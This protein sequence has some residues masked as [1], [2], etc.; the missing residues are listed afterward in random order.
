M[1]DISINE[2]QVRLLSKNN[3]ALFCKYYRE[4]SFTIYSL[5]YGVLVFT[6]WG[7]LAWSVNGITTTPEGHSAAVKRI[8]ELQNRGKGCEE[9]LLELVESDRA[10]VG[11]QKNAR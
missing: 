4:T 1:I 5:D 11:L 3:Q 9:F 7:T 2:E 8:S 10:F 6:P